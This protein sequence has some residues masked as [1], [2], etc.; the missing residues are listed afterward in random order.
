ML[1][2]SLIALALLAS[3]T[4]MADN[5]ATVS[6]Q[7]KFVDNGVLVSD[8]ATFGLGLQFNDV[9]VDGAFIRADFNTLSDVT[10]LND[11]V[12]VRTDIGAG[13]GGKVAGNEWAVSLNRVM[14]P[15]IYA[16]DY[17]EAR[18]RL[19]RG[20][21]FAELNQGLTTGVNKN[22]YIAT[23]LQKSFNGLT[24]GGLVSTVRY[25]D[26]ALTLREEFEYNNSEVFAR[27]NAWKNLD[28]NVNYSFGGHKAADAAIR[29]QV[30]GGVS[31]RF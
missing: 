31:Y 14:N 29:D 4:A 2:A 18:T 1:K 7:T 24:V 22:T 19:T 30:W 28:V 21:W 17:T 8:T 11:T 10:P 15:I 20:V 3:N 9:L 5:T 12:S 6:A 23:G 13:F 27:Y 16:A 25:S 26:D